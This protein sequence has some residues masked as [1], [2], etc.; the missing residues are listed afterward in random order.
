MRTHKMRLLVLVVMCLPFVVWG[1]EFE[2]KDYSL[3]GIEFSRKGYKFVKAEKSEGLDTMF[4][5]DPITGDVIMKTRPSNPVPATMNGKKIYKLKE[6]T[7]PPQAII[8]TQPLAEYLLDNLKGTIREFK[9]DSLTIK[10]ELK[11][12]IVDEK[13]TIVY[14]EF[15][16]V[17]GWW[18]DET[19][20]TL[21]RGELGDKIESLLSKAPSMKPAMYNGK[22]VPA[23]TDVSLEYF[24]IDILK[25]AVTYRR[26]GNKGYGRVQH[27]GMT[28]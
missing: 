26:T 1:Q 18:E 27:F 16:S 24:E 20:R 7:T 28:K 2:N 14:F 19:I 3:G 23:Y 25:P 6:V 17:K 5:Q 11:N 8:G 9:V 15:G 12:I 4:I 21:G 13:G 10:I 22:A